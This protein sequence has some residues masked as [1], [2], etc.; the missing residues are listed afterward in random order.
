MTSSEEGEQRPQPNGSR[1]F[2]WLAIGIVAAIAAYTGGWFWAAGKVETETARFL[3]TLRSRGQEADCANAQAKGYPFRLGLFCDGVAFADPRLGLALSGTGLRSAAQIYQPTKIVGELD[4]L[5]GDLAAPGGSVHVNWSDIRFSTHLAKPLP[6]IL[7]A[8]SG[9]VTVAD[10]D[11]QQLAAASDAIVH[12]RPRAADVDLAGRMN[13]VTVAALASLPPVAAA[14]DATV[15]NGVALLL[16]PD[17]SLRGASGELRDLSIVA[18]DGSIAVTGKA[19]ID[20]DGLIDADLTVKLNNPP[21]IVRL[22][23]A[24]LPDLAPRLQ[25]AEKLVS[26]MGDNPTVPVTISKGEVRLG[27]FSIGRIPPIGP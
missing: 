22:I 16:S 15:L 24:A 6:S 8:Q 4:H 17:R 10:P 25:Q 27:F 5:T 11:G 19:A 20:Q 26:L 23:S 13:G 9:S 2:A 18:P 14:I 7:S 3:D 21:A 12:F 1:R